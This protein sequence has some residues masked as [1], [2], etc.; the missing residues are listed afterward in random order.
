[1]SCRAE[2]CVLLFNYVRGP[3]SSNDDQ[4]LDRD[5]KALVNENAVSEHLN[6]LRMNHSRTSH[7]V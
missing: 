3:F 2:G 6:C 4:S 7:L 1:M 5:L